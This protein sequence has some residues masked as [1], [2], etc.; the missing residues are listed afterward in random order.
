[1]I[2][3]LINRYVCMCSVIQSYL[4]LCDPMDHSPPGS[5]VHGILQARI[6]EWVAI[7]NS[8]GSTQ[9]RKQT[10]ISCIS[11]IGRR[12]LYLLHHLHACMLSHF[13]YVWL[14]ETLCSPPGSSVH[15]IHQ[16]RILKWVAIS[17]SREYSWL[18]DQTHVSH[19]S[20]IGRWVLYHKHHLWS[21]S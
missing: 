21:L 20:C 6:L 10:L 17:F 7:S 2:V 19:V 16:A 18:R 12:I 8:S 14:F 9:T 5:S 15:R 1:M 11:W 3:F 4:T 13:S